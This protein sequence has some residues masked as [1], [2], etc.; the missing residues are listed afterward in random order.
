MTPSATPVP[1]T[2]DV[3]VVAAHPDDAEISVGGTIATMI[4]RGLRVGIVD[5][6]TGEPTPRGS[7]ET[8]RR[9]TQA[10]NEALGSPWRMNLGLANR[11][12]VDD[13]AGRRAL[14]EVIRSTEPRLLLGP[15]PTD[16]HPDHVAAA[17]LVDAARFWAKLS[18][19]DLEGERHWTPRLLHYWSIHLRLQEQPSIVVD[20]SAAFE[21]KMTAVRSYRSQ[22]PGPDSPFPTVIDDIEA[23]A[24][25]WGWAV[26]VAYGEPLLDRETVGVRDV[27]T[28]LP[29]S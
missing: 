7:L 11:R 13:E 1:A 5:L 27:A 17:A 10:A 2:L 8:R 6:T 29:P 22:M 21:R 12:L 20:V 26:Q 25:Y 18:R 9:E 24:R 3:L 28:L 16:V 15:Y 14:A 23:R 19:T 4:D